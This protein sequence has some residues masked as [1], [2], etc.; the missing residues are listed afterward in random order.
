MQGTP[1]PSPFS[2]GQ[3]DDWIG[4]RCPNRPAAW[5]A[6]LGLAA[7]AAWLIY[8]CSGKLTFFREERYVPA[9]LVQS[10]LLALCCLGASI[11]AIRL[12]IL[13]LRSARLPATVGRGRA[14]AG[15]ALGSLGLLWV[16]I[17]LLQTADIAIPVK[18]FGPDRKSVV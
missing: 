11:A 12:G 14:M 6:L 17:M 4:L 10:L 3:T 7:N 2:A 1:P 18:V 8:H 16:L 5:A 15:I 13:G 9:M